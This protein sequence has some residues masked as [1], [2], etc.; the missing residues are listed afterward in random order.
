MRG[1]VRPDVGRKRA[2]VA[3]SLE[4]LGDREFHEV[5]LQLDDLQP[6]PLERTEPIT[7]VSKHRRARHND[8]LAIALIPRD[9]LD[10]IGNVARKVQIKLLDVTLA[11]VVELLMP[12]WIDQVTQFNQFLVRPTGLVELLIRIDPR[13][14]G[15]G[16]DDA[17]AC[18]A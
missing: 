8:Q 6:R 13:S 3:E 17:A 11:V 5:A 7:Q 12:R 14:G 9:E 4:K 2:Q 10:G 18:H 16:D 15:V 1:R